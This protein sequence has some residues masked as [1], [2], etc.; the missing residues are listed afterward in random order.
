[1]SPAV[2]ILI[3]KPIIKNIVM[4]SA[5]EKQQTSVL[6]SGTMKKEMQSPGLLRGRVSDA[7]L[8]LADTTRKVFVVPAQVLKNQAKTS[9]LGYLIYEN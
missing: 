8:D 4:L 2:K 3:E 1:M 6:C 7:K 9:F 5:A